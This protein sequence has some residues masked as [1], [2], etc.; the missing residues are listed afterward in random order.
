MNLYIRVL[1]VIILNLFGFVKKSKKPTEIFSQSFRTWPHDLDFNFHMNNGRYLTIM[2]IGRL[3][4][5]LRLGLFGTIIQNLW[6]PIVG[7]AYI[8]FRRSLAPF[9]KF[10]LQT[11]IAAWDDKWFYIEQTFTQNGEVMATGYVKGLIRGKKRNI[12]T[13]ELLKIAG[14]VENSPPIPESFQLL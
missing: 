6:M 12:P 13:K 4:L 1:K 5:M 3:D 7:T 10:T 8:R 9:K 14:I 11:Q 2:D